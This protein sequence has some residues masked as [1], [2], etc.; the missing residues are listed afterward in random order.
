VCSWGLHGLSTGLFEGW[1]ALYAAAVVLQAK[2][3]IRALS[4]VLQTCR[5][6]QRRAAWS[7][8]QRT[9]ALPALVMRPLRCFSPLLL[10][11]GTKPK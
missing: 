5:R 2:D 6:Q 7:K 4:P 8:S 10:S 11:L 9:R 1:G 3:G